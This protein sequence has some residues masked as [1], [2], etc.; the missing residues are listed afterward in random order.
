MTCK[1]GLDRDLIDCLQ[2]EAEE[3]ARRTERRTSERRISPAVGEFAIQ[4][5]AR[6]K[7]EIDKL[8]G[9]LIEMSNAPESM[10]SSWFIKQAKD[11][12]ADGQS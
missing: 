1:H 10:S 5:N 6:L 12:I 7:N 4:E 2:C 11:A 9:L 8:L 3:K